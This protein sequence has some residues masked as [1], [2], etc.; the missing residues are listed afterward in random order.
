M[1][2][3]IKVKLKD[4]SERIINLD[5]AQKLVSER[6]LVK[7]DDGKEY[8]VESVNVFYS[9]TDVEKLEGVSM[10]QI[11]E[12]VKKC[13]DDRDHKLDQILFMLCKIDAELAQKKTELNQIADETIRKVV[14]GIDSQM[15]EIEAAMDGYT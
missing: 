3:I 7:K 8:I 10:A 11:D 12:A 1:S 13:H 9:K 4:G 2:E 14:A 5:K 15:A 6:S